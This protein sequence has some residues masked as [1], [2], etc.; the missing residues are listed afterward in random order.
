MPRTPASIS[1][2]E[3]LLIAGAA[4]NAVGDPL[5]KLIALGLLDQADERLNV[6]LDRGERTLDLL[7][8]Q[9]GRFCKNAKS[10]PA[11]T[12]PT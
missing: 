3:E 6:P 12:A 1:A 2:L 7:A 11:A 5:Q 10:P 4:A 9:G 8:R